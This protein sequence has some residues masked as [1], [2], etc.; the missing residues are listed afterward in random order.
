MNN[1]G[2]RP[3]NERLTNQSGV[4]T[5]NRNCYDRT[6]PRSDAYDLLR[7]IDTGD[8]PWLGMTFGLSISAVWYWCS[9]QV[10]IQYVPLLL[11]L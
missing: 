10:G 8:L 1:I 4:Y 9:D 2:A 3:F 5:D 6:Q 7:A 11:S